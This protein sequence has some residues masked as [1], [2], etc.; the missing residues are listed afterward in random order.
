MKVSE[1]NSYA[2][3][4]LKKEIV[5]PTGWEKVGVWLKKNGKTI[6]YAVGG[7]VVGAGG[8]YMLMK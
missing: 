8:T 4:N 6:G 1:I 2:I 5:D 3:P 7:V